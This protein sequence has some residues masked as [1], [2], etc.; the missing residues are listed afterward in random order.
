MSTAKFVQSFG[1]SL[2]VAFGQ[3]GV[4]HAAPAG[5]DVPSGTT[6]L[7]AQAVYA[8][9]RELIGQGDD[10]EAVAHLDQ[11]A[12]L[13]PT[14]TAPIRLRAEVFARLAERYRP[15]EAFMSAR[16][17]D[18]QRL[19]ALEPGVDVEGRQAEIAALKRQREAAYAREQRLRRLSAP[20]LLVITASAALM[21]SGAMLYAMKPNDFLK[22]TAYRYQHR[23]AA[24]LG[25][26]M[27]GA[28]LVPPAIVLGVLA[29]RQARR[30]SAVREFQV[31][32][33][34]PRASLGMGPQYVS[35]GS[36]MRISLWF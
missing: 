31:T 6:D 16:A 32:T 10:F 35:A 8:R 1:L 21:I 3:P 13:E 27:A 15:S 24:G 20:A 17:A 4:A 25:M 5:A 22:P 14:W 9:A 23:D 26:L 29:G 18:L 12:E 19:L 36:G 28:V 2:S 33:A 7:S 11:A 30:D 34:R